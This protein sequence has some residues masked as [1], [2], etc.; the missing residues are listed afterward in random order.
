MASPEPAILIVFGA[1]V[2]TDGTPSGALLRRVKG[3]AALARLY[4]D[5]ILIVSGGVHLAAVSESAVMKS[6]LLAEGIPEGR[7][8]EDAD[9][10]DTLESVIHCA[11]LVRRYPGCH[12]VIACSDRYHMP[13]CCWL[14]RLVGIPARPGKMPSARRILGATRWLFWSLR[15]IPATIADTF[16]LL[17]R[18]L[19][20]TAR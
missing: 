17:A 3:A 14:F 19:A 11:R 6:L 2:R 15:E 10:T 9:S 18:L 8:V 4:E 20:G 12:T 5:S 1:V 16:L 7:I 13:R